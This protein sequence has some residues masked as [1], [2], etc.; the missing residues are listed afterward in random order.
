MMRWGFL[1]TYCFLLFGGTTAIVV[2]HTPPALP[3]HYKAVRT[4]EA[5]RLLQPGDLTPE[6]T[7][8]YLRD[9][10]GDKEALPPD[11]TAALPT[12]VV[13]KDTAPLALPVARELVRS[14]TANAGGA[15]RICQAG[16][17]LVGGTVTVQAALCA[18]DDPH[19]IAVLDVPAKKVEAVASAYA[20]SKPP[21]IV[22]T[23]S[24]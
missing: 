2:T 9:K 16:K 17:D 3:L 19:C 22:A 13:H 18:E 8:G 10:L 24:N 6:P 7:G 1:I 23:C 14:G 4:L 21:S 5:N 11:G 15:V 12:I 20:D